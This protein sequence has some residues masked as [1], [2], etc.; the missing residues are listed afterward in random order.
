MLDKK[1]IFGIGDA[2]MYGISFTY[3]ELCIVMGLRVPSQSIDRQ[4]QHLLASM[5]GRIC[6]TTIHVLLPMLGSPRLLTS[7]NWST[8]TPTIQVKHPRMDSLCRH[9]CYH[10]PSLAP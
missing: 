6:A 7:V 5:V 9:L 4:D 8:C 3:V 10:H 1:N 2:I